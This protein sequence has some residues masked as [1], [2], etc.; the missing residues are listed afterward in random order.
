MNQPKV[1]FY[2]LAKDVLA[3]TTTR[4]GGYSTGPYGEFNI[5]HYCGDNPETVR[6]NRKALCHLLNIEDDHLILPRQTHQTEIR[7][8]D[9]TF[10]SLNATERQE[11][12]EGVDGVIT[13]LPGVCIGVSTADCIP[14]LIYDPV[15]RVA[16]AVHAGWRGT[17]ARIVEKA[18]T[19]MEAQYGAQPQ[20]MVAQIGPGISL[21][22]FEVGDEVYEAFKQA[23][24][25]MAQISKRFST[26]HSSPFTSKWHIDLPQCNR[27]QLIACGLPE[28]AVA[29]SPICT[30]QHPDTHF[31]A[32]RLGIHSGRLFTGIMIITP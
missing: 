16:C 29:L 31:S 19:T 20:D 25:N 9:E 6:Q 21:D 5:T 32:R 15:K 26:L 10:L 18:I 4:Q 3:F 1:G 27:L 8:I 14:V 2:D 13:A 12:L 24:F 30:Y 17:V 28:G 7:I 11:A 22:S 23:D